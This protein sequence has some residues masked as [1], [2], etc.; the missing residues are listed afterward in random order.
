MRR[1]P[2]YTAAS[3]FS[4]A[5]RV[6]FVAGAEVPHKVTTGVRPKAQLKACDP[7]LA[8]LIRKCWHQQGPR[9]PAFAEVVAEV[10]RML[11]GG[12]RAGGSRPASPGRHIGGAE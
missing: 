2:F 12:G 4:P 8:D 6:H 5:Q 9:R 3:I 11:S 7:A 1:K 10:E